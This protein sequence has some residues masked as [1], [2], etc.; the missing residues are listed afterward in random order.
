ML[1][2]CVD[3]Q[4]LPDRLPLLWCG[5]LPQPYYLSDE[6]HVFNNACL[7]GCLTHTG[8]LSGLHPLQ[9]VWPITGNPS[10]KIITPVACLGFLVGFLGVPSARARVVLG[11]LERLSGFGHPLDLASF[12]FVLVHTIPSRFVSVERSPLDMTIGPCL[13][14]SGL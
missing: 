10:H 7:S 12:T 6:G 5:L 2:V 13:V 8:E 3:G 9:N 1:L 14:S 11:R 4:P